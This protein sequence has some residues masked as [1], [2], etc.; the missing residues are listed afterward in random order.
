MTTVIAENFSSPE[1]GYMA[2]SNFLASAGVL[3]Q[4]ISKIGNAIAS[5]FGWL[6]ACLKLIWTAQSE[7]LR[8]GNRHGITRNAGTILSIKIIH[9]HQKGIHRRSGSNEQGAVVGA[10]KIDIGWVFRRRYVTQVIPGRV[11]HLDLIGYCQV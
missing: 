3:L 7:A 1:T 10:T 4:G 9:L 2:I 8:N 11:I 6:C 5:I